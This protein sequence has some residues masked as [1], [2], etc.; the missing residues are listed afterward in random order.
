MRS[1]PVRRVL[2]VFCQAKSVRSNTLYKEQVQLLSVRMVSSLEQDPEPWELPGKFNGLPAELRADLMTAAAYIYLDRKD[3]AYFPE[4]P[5]ELTWVIVTLAE[6][7]PQVLEDLPSAAKMIEQ[8]MKE[9][10][11]KENASTEEEK[12]KSKEIEPDKDAL[13]VLLESEIEKL[14]DELSLAL[15][16]SNEQL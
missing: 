11:A 12:T 5:D 6:Q 15:D 1:E 2:T 10:K 13:N 7:L 9:S 3:S 16:M 14:Q 4:L 8:M